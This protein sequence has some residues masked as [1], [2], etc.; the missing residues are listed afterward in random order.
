MF[1][2]FLAAFLFSISVISGHRTA[3]IIGGVEAN[4]WRLTCATLFLSAW[5][6]TGG[7][8]VSGAGFPLF[9]LS[10][11]VGIGIGDAGLFQALP[12]LGSRLSLL[13]I[14]CLTAPIAA[15][16]EWL[17][18]GTTLGPMEII[19]ALVILAGV[20]VAIAPGE[21]ITIPR[22]RLVT[23]GLFGL[24][25]AAGNALGVVLSRK[26]YAVTHEDLQTIDGGTAAFQRILGGLLVSAILLLFA[27]RHFF[28][29][30]GE[31]NG[32]NALA[33]SMREKWRRI[34]PWVL[35][36]SLAGQTLGVSAM[37][38]GLETTPTGVVMSIVALTPL[39]VIPLARVF[40]GEKVTIRS[41]LGGAIAVTGVICLTLS[42]WSLH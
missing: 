4:F 28:P 1:A 2:A 38:W 22:P 42:K 27:K 31:S 33:M 30:L 12:R 40:E 34:W 23:G 9:L 5:A 26:A 20:G 25:G 24:L 29:V 16:I 15:L 41:L 17:W 14:Q 11:L 37:Q 13:I 18:L 21:H 8:G 35:L 19:G 7:S 6:F 32:N 36:N 3:K 10:G 39:T